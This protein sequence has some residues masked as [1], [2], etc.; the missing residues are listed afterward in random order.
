[1]DVIISNCAINLFADND[2]VLS[3]AFRVLKPTGFA[4]GIE[5]R[6]WNAIALLVDGKFISA[7]V[8]ASKPIF[9]ATKIGPALNVLKAGDQRQS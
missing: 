3:E 7:F 8:R 4:V 2:C 9:A 1:V 6:T 5:P